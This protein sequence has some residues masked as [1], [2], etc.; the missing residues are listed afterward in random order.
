MC[1]DSRN[2]HVVASAQVELEEGG[3]VGIFHSK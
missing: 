3:G 1:C 2:L